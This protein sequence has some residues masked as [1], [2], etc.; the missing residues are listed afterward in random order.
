MNFKT[1]LLYLVVFVCSGADTLNVEVQAQRINVEQD[2][3]RLYS[4]C[5]YGAGI[6]RCREDVRKQD[7]RL[8]EVQ[9]ENRD[10]REQFQ[11]L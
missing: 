5:G 10:L 1:I 2:G 9:T 3:S 8:S 6:E 4:L 11:V 7:V